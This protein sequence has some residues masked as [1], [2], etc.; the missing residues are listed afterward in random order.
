MGKHETGYARVERDGYNSPPWVARAL[1]EHVHLEERKV[2]EP[3]A[4]AGHLARALESVGARVFA[5]DITAHPD[6]DAR[7]D[8]LT[9]GLPPGLRQ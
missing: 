6:L 9:P 2:W 5:S 3:A 7:F 8:F 4:G 1:A